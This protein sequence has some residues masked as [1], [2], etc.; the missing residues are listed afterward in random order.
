MGATSN[1]RCVGTTILV[2][3]FKIASPVVIRAIGDADTLYGGMNLPGSVLDDLRQT[4]P[5]MVEIEP[6]QKM[7]LPAFSGTT[8]FKVAKVPEDK[9]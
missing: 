5:N 8:S 7:R 3:G 4:D 6:V 9:K 2:D 1:F